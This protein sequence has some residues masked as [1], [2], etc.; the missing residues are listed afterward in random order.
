VD[1][2]SQ[3]DP[4]NL[5]NGPVAM[6]YRR[7]VLEPGATKPAAQL[8]QDFLGRP[9]SLDALKKWIDVQFTQPEGK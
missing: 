4:N 7:T 6:R 9:Q 5:L 8:V 1:F 2:F 3:F